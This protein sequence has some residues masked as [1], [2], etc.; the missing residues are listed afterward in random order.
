MRVTPL[1]MIWNGYP[2]DRL[3]GD[4]GDGP[5]TVQLAAPEFG[6]E[7]LRSRLGTIGV[8]VN[9]LPPLAGAFKDDDGRETKIDLSPYI[10]L[11]EKTEGDD[12]LMKMFGDYFEDEGRFR[13]MAI[14]AGARSA[15]S[16]RSR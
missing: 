15:A 8:L 1:A 9:D 14:P 6:I 3:E 11:V 7:A 16:A 4:F 13:D 12:G 5:Q 2:V 10:L